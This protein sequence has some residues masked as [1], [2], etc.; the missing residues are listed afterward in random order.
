M[1][2]RKTDEVSCWTVAVGN[3][4]FPP[5]MPKNTKKAIEYISRLDG[6]VGFHF[7]YPNGTL[8]LFESENDAKI[9]RNLMKSKGIQT[10][11]NICE[12][13]VPKKDIEKA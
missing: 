4:P 1:S 9:A 8:C 13:F 7:C 10:G 5:F 12:V 3:F 6:F 11:K 2:E